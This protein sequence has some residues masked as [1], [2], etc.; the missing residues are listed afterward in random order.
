MNAAQANEAFTKAIRLRESGD[1][2]GFV[3]TMETLPLHFVHASSPS[4]GCVVV[5]GVPIGPSSKPIHL[6]FE[7]LKEI[8]EP[9]PLLVYKGVF[10]N[11][12]CELAAAQQT[13][14][15]SLP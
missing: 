1:T 9:S 11:D 7:E 4:T 8:G 5:G 12:P 6:A 3:K 14:F 10:Y 2:K 15:S 13:N